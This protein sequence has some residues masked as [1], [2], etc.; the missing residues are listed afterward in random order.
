MFESVLIANRGEIAVRIIRTC[1]R[2]G[3]RAIAVYSAADRDALHVR[4]ADAAYAIGPA[5]SARSYLDAGAIVAAARRAGA[6]AIHPGYGFLS[7]SEALIAACED[8]GI[9]FV[10]PHREAI[11]AMGSKIAAK[12]IAV[13]AG[14]P[15]VPGYHEE[16]QSDAALIAAA[17]RIGFPL[18]IKASAGGGG[19]GMRAVTRSEEFP[20]ALALARAEAL[21][22]FGDDRILL[23]KLVAAPRHI[24]VQLAGD[25]RG[26]LVHLFER[27]CSIQRNHQKVIEEAPAA[28]LSAAQRAALHRHAL[29][30]G[31]AI[32]YDSLGTVEF[33]LDD[34]S[35]E[36]YF[37]EMN[38]RL[39]VEHP[40]TEYVTGL[41]L[42]EWQLRSAAGEP[43]PLA[44]EQ[45]QC[46]GWAIEARI[47]AEDPAQNYLP[48]TGAI[49]HYAAPTGPELR[50]DSGVA[51]GS[52][53]TPHY[54]SLLA[55]AITGGTDRE[56]ARRR[57][58]GALEDF[59]IV[60]PVTN[61]GLLR[62]IMRL[63]EFT[64]APLTTGFLARHFPGGWQA[65]AVPADVPMLAALALA[66]LGEAE[67]DTASPWQTLGAF[68]LLETADLP[69]IAYHRL[70]TADG[71][72]HEIQIAGRAGRYR[73]GCGER[74]F[75]AAAQRL[76]GDTLAVEI[77]GCREHLALRRS[78]ERLVLRRGTGVHEL[79][80]PNPH[81]AA[82]AAGS[83][84]HRITA[85]LPGRVAEIRCAPGDRVGVGDVLVVLDSMKLLQ[86][87]TAACDGVVRELFC[88]PDDSVEGGALLVELEPSPATGS[89]A[90]SPAD[91]PTTN[92]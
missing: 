49:E 57:L 23:E 72:C 88:A 46:T 58:L 61:L 11:R 27:E 43:L 29:A 78:G 68:R 40:V 22:G 60:G 82:A 50:I 33:L 16:D 67:Y 62:D 89:P 41:D 75:T 90:N 86:S 76:D 51:A 17:E 5:E 26:N 38:T 70:A 18:L 71:E 24:E 53:I 36:L 39:Q 3:I 6:E 79:R 1:R 59:T 52:V 83:G 47:N 64:A 84:D 92:S 20:A 7:E 25:R 37:L 30:L 54:D 15:V 55:K 19:R 56:Q 66:V 63:P 44:Q 65:P 42:V 21:A 77:D 31:R 91:S 80:I 45:I 69:G 35:G 85:T 8:A 87:L 73:V 48:G 9:A 34:D 28:F 32:G 4:L 74:H 81:S 2:L 13:A 14:V 12:A 10:G